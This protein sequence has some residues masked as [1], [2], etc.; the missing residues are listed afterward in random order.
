MGEVTVTGTF[1]SAEP[2]LEDATIVT[3]TKRPKEIF[4]RSSIQDA[5]TDRKLSKVI[6]SP[7]DRYLTHNFDEY[8]LPN[9]SF[10]RDS[11]I[12]ANRN[13]GPN[14]NAIKGKT[15]SCNTPE[16]KVYIIIIPILIMSLYRKITSSSDILFVN[17][18]PF[19]VFISQTIKSRMSEQ[20]PTPTLNKSVKAIKN[21]YAMQG[22]ITSV[23]NMDPEFKPLRINLVKM[24]VLLNNCTVGEYVPEVER[25]IGTCKDLFCG[26]YCALLFKYLTLT[27][28]IQ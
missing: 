19:L 1:L 17:K 10:S 3:T 23:L 6:F 16:V 25:Y 22:F 8:H 18:V 15:L 11:I 4:T 5:T 12:T 2:D 26:L 9:N 24:R 21:M 20:N 14:T 7:I 13:Y 27:M 28:T